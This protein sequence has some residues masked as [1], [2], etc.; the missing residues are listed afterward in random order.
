MIDMLVRLLSF[1]VYGFLLNF[2]FSSWSSSTKLTGRRF[3]LIVLLVIVVGI[4]PLLVSQMVTPFINML[5]TIFLILI[6]AG[7]YQVPQPETIFWII[8]L[9]AID[10]ICESLSLTLFESIMSP[11]YSSQSFLFVIMTTSMT[12]VTEILLILGIKFF[13]LR[14]RVYYQILT[15]KIFLALGSVPVVSIVVLLSFLLPKVNVRA[16]P[17]FFE[18]LIVFGILYMNICVLYLY[19]SVADH[20]RQLNQMK[21]QKKALESEMKYIKEIKKSQETIRS[22]RHDLKN[23]FLVLSGLLE[24][25]AVTEAKEYLQTSIE[26][27]QAPQNFY[28][29]DSVLNYLLNEKM[30]LA[31][32]E[33][34]AFKIKVL[35]SERITIDHDVLAILVGNLIDN[36]LDATRRLDDGVSRQVS[37]VIKQANSN[38]LIEI[39]N[40]YNP[41]EIKT[42][43]NRKID[44]LGIKNVKKIVSKYGGLYKQWSEKSTYFVSIVLL[45]IY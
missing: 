44:G 7:R 39:S 22:I 12:M 26:A 30:E 31:K 6:I 1:I 10:F 28:T 15:P 45:N 34:V 18:I 36:A 19:N 17:I 3:F 20:F 16:Q 13:F 35:L 24:R 8:L 14:H 29:H 21:L 40:S 25:S 5:V 32:K 4:T 9:L 23:Q 33:Q 37:L 42:R 2:F 27:V 43:K 11:T 38:L 41:T